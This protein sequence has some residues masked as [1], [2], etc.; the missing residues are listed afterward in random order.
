[1]ITAYGDAETKHK[2]LENGAEALLTSPEVDV[3]FDSHIDFAAEPPHE[4]ADSGLSR[5]RTA[6]GGRF[7]SCRTSS[8]QLN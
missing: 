7:E 5:C 3:E 8:P 4:G 6:A 2:A 1:M